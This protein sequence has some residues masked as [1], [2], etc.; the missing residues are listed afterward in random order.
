[1][2]CRTVCGDASHEMAPE[3]C[4]LRAPVHLSHP[5]LHGL[6]LSVDQSS[7][8]DGGLGDGQQAGGPAGRWWGGQI[9]QE[10]N[11]QDGTGSQTGGICAAA[12]VPAHLS[13]PPPPSPLSLACCS[14]SFLKGSQP[15]S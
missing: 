15:K 13:S 8:G 14:F 9:S 1:M 10:I 5:K 7:A 6:P 12:H 11:T 3:V 2:H 4:V